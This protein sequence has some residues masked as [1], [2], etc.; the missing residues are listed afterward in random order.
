I[1]SN[2]ARF[3]G[4]KYGHS[5]TQNTK[6]KTQNLLDIYLKSRGEGFGS[7]AKRRIM[8]GTYTLS[9]GYYDAYYLKAQKVRALIK[10]DFDDAFENVDII[11]TPTTPNVAFKIGEH[12]GNPVEMYMEDIFVSAVSLAG[13]PALSVPCGFA[14]PKD[15]ETE[16]PIGMQIIGKP[17]DESGILKAASIYEKNTEWHEKVSSI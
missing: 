9:S 15:G 3:D 17:F 16:M 7:E 6:H 10:K 2:L 11:I 13:L 4:I 1:S 14:K 8:L 5:E 12:S